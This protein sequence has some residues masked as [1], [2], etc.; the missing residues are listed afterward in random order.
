MRVSDDLAPIMWAGGALGFSNVA[1]TGVYLQ[2]ATREIVS[3]RIRREYSG[4]ATAP[5]T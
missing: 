5:D 3:P 4:D 2:A 1:Q